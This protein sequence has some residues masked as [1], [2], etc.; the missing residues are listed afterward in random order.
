MNRGE[1]R[2]NGGVGFAVHNPETKFKFQENQI[3]KV[4]DERKDGL[5]LNEIDRLLN[6]LENVRTQYSFK[7]SFSLR[8]SGKSRTHF[9]FGIGTTVRLACLE[10]LFLINQVSYSPEILQTLSGRGGTSGIGIHTYFCGGF[11]FDLGH[12]VTGLR[13]Q[14]SSSKEGKHSLPLLSQQIEMP[15]WNFGICIPNNIASK[16]E[17][18]ER[19][20]F[21]KT[22]PISSGEVYETLYHTVYGL[23]GAVLEDDQE[24]FC[25]ALVAIQ[26]CAWKSAERQLYGSK[27]L[28]FEKALYESG[29]S[30]VGMSSL[31]PSL[32]FFSQDVEQ[33]LEEMRDRRLQCDLLLTHPVNRG[34]FVQ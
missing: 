5:A 6:M 34:R 22:C 27:L 7:N 10:A 32:F 13:H 16:E 21:E 23:Y 14:P 8:I 25:K 30:A 24:T 26:D 29:A 20:F 12:K 3:F 28:V 15:A 19:I 17:G 1:Y 31:G 33:V 18:Q 9:G 11:V 2:I 4:V